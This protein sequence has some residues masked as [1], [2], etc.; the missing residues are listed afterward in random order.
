MINGEGDYQIPLEISTPDTSKPKDI[1]KSTKPVRDLI[2]DKLKPAAE[3]V[4]VGMIA[5][6]VRQ[7]GIA[8]DSVASWVKQIKDRMRQNLNHGGFE[9]AILSYRDEQ[10]EE[11]DFV[12]DGRDLDHYLASRRVKTIRTIR[13]K[14][15]NPRL[16]KV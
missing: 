4:S 13:E 12:V 5:A 10:G 2:F 1:K 15:R 6:V 9:V 8:P 14:S 3:P 16:T 7:M 11:Q